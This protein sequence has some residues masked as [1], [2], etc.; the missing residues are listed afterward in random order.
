ME[1]VGIAPL[2]AALE[3]GKLAAIAPKRNGEVTRLATPLEF[4]VLEGQLLLL[5]P[6]PVEG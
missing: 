3:G 4:R 1:Q 6:D 5:K 2:T